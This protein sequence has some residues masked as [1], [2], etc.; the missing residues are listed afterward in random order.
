L[1]YLWVDFDRVKN[2][3][4]ALGIAEL[5]HTKFDSVISVGRDYGALV[6]LQTMIMNLFHNVVNEEILFEFFAQ[7]QYLMFSLDAIVAVHAPNQKTLGKYTGMGV[8]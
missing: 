3:A 4:V 1:T 5:D 2:A 8:H 7:Y 6:K